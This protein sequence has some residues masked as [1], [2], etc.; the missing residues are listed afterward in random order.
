MMSRKKYSKKA[1][2]LKLLMFLTLILFVFS[3]SKV[4]SSLATT[5]AFS[6]TNA[7]IVSKSDSVIVNSFNVSD[8]TIVNNIEFHKVGDSVTYKLTIKNDDSKCYTLKSITDTGSSENITF[9]YDSYAGTKIDAGKSHSFEVTAKYSKGLGESVEREKVLSTKLEF[10][11]EDENGNMSKKTISVNDVVNPKTGDNIKLYMT[12]MIASFLMLLILFRRNSVIKAKQ[13][14]KGKHSEGKK[15]KGVIKFMVLLLAITI[16]VPNM[17]KASSTPFAI[18][19]ENS[20]KLYDKVVITYTVDG[21]TV[22]KVVNYGEVPNLQTPSKPGY[23]FKGWKYEDGSPYDPNTPI[24]GDLKLVPIFEKMESN[25]IVSVSDE[26]EETLSKVVTIINELTNA[27][28]DEVQTQYSTDG[29]NTW[30]NYTEP[31]TI[32]SDGDIQIRTVTVEDGVVIGSA[33]VTIDNIKTASDIT[34]SV[35]DE[36]T[37]TDSKNITIETQLNNI[38]D[39]EVQNQY[40][41][42]GGQTWNDYT[43]PITVADNGTIKVRTVKKED[44]TE[45]GSAEK[46]I[47]NLNPRSEIVVTVGEKDPETNTKPVTIETEL[48][49]IDEEDVKTQYS[50]DGGQ[51]WKDYTGPFDAE[52]NGDI[53]VRIVTKDDGTVIGNAETTIDELDPKSEMTITVSNENT[54]TDSK[55]IT[56]DAELHNIFEDEVKIQYSTDGG[57]TWN[58]YTGPIT[59]EDNGTIKVRTIKTDDNSVIGSEEKTISNLNPRSDI[60]ITVTDENEETSSKQVTIETETHNL[61]GGN[62]TTQYSLDNG[63]TWNDYTGPITVRNEGDILVRVIDEGGTVIGEETKT[64][65]NILILNSTFATGN[66]LNNKFKQFALATI[67]ADQDPYLSILEFKKYNGEKDISTFT[68]DNIVSVDGAA[69]P[70]YAWLDNGKVY[71][72]SE[73]QDVALNSDASG[74][75]MAFENMTT[76]DLR[77]IDCSKGHATATMFAG[78]KS[79]TDLKYDGTLKTTNPLAMFAGCE[80]LSEI[81]TARIDTSEA[82]TLLAMFDTCY[83]LKSIDLSH[84]DATNVRDLGGMFYS[85]KNLETINLIGFDTK[86]VTSMSGVFSGCSKLKNID[87]SEFDTRSVEE[88]GGLFSGCSGLTSL[89]LS[90]FNTSNVNSMTAMFSG[91][92]SLTTLDLSSFNTNNVNYMGYMF[93]DCTN[94]ETIYVS[95]SFTAANIDPNAINIDMFTNDTKLVG[96]AGTTYSADHLK[97]DYA[98]VDEP[99]EGKPGYFTFKT[100]NQ[101]AKVTISVSDENVETTSKQVTIGTTLYN[102]DEGDITI[103]YSID[104]GTTWNDYIG[105]ITVTDEGD[106]LVR[107]ID[108]HGT[109]IGQSSKIVTNIVQAPVILK[110]GP[111]INAEMKRLAGNTSNNITYNTVDTQIKAFRHAETKP[112]ISSITYSDIR[113]SGDFPVYMWFDNGTIYWWSEAETVKTQNSQDMFAF[114]KGIIDADLRGLDLTT[115]QKFNRTFADCDLLKNVYMENAAPR[116]LSGIFAKCVSLESVDVSTWDT[117]ECVSLFN[118]FAGCSNLKS[119]NLSNFDTSNTTSMGFMF[120]NCTRLEEVNL[121]NFNIS[122]ITSLRGMF[123]ECPKLTVLDL[124]S[125]NTSNVTDMW[126]A[127]W[128]C[129]SL[130]TIYVS[131]NFDTT[132]VTDGSEMFTDCENLVGGEGTTYSSANAGV[133]YAKIDDP[134]NGNPG[135]F[136]LKQ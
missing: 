86:N 20:F 38:T 52:D 5:E 42:D 76:A 128:K 131:P 25:I 50:T 64:I 112:D 133:E 73:A 40:S 108:E 114:L 11:F 12:L 39:D 115:V 1:K 136:T 121:S 33:S 7:E 43:G 125:F 71:W 122:K 91:C 36:N 96:G 66:S 110:D 24:T 113:S 90:N 68:A 126:L 14:K 15:N 10:T 26:D 54:P 59:V 32:N 56:I 3:L 100:S 97:P 124:S 104:G 18:K 69:T 51:T 102:I 37:A 99:E 29:G 45:I 8:T 127:F 23:V 77:G 78:C 132:N 111:T 60:T 49:N 53:D 6:L 34:I 95:E 55:Q 83:S 4:G 92:S 62:T 72:W 94:L 61:D 44:G 118:M 13:N 67:P 119:A 93:D 27:T 16:M 19:F 105:P 81:D 31:V 48:H 84:F 120:A 9:E 101:F 65:D 21:Q 129:T 79:L 107:V 117:S 89:D 82:T 134:A 106:L 80:Q 98:R 28:E 88:I 47:S 2:S 17:V 41:L 58:D 22:Q 30:K 75:F 85:C 123:S 116:D 130:K 103:Q 74:L 35:S 57:N 87:L 135:Y 70:I 46:T 109:V 63:E